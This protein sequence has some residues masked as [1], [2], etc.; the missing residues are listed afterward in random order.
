M[1]VC[2]QLGGGN[3]FKFFHESCPGCQHVRVGFSMNLFNILSKQL[4]G[5]S[6]F[7]YVSLSVEL[8]LPASC[9]AVVYLLY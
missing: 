7:S 3:N 4:S 1:F 9:S 6:C 8:G 2:G 5:F